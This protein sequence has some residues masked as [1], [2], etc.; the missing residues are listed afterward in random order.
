VSGLSDERLREIERWVE[1]AEVRG[2]SFAIADVHVAYEDRAD[3]LAE[4]KRLRAGIRE[5]ADQAE[6][7]VDAKNPLSPLG[8][9]LLTAQPDDLRALLDPKE[10]TDD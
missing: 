4:V 8:R 10:E 7:M 5:L 1:R 6:R 2:V 9:A 3:L